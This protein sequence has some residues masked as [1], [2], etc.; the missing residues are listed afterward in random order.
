MITYLPT[1][2]HSSE[3]T[4]T[5]ANLYFFIKLND[6]IF[7]VFIFWL[8][9]AL[10][11]ICV[12]NIYFHRIKFLKKIPREWFIKKTSHIIG[13]VLYQATASQVSPRLTVWSP[14]LTACASPL[15]ILQH[16]RRHNLT[17]GGSV[18]K[19][20]IWKFATGEIVPMEHH[21]CLIT[22][23]WCKN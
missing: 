14:P 9:L 7:P 12:S 10:L 18:W 23:Q 3:S 15:Q 19:S 22:L 13:K 8:S 2:E 21:F 16:L 4:A 5:A 20:K 17:V 1:V 6:H 11:L